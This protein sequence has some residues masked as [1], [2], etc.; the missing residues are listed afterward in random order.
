[1]SGPFHVHPSWWRMGNSV[2]VNQQ[3]QIVHPGVANTAG[4]TA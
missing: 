1:M 4:S 2:S 3:Q